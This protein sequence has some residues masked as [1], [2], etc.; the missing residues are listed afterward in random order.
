MLTTLCHRCY[1]VLVYGLGRWP[2]LLLAVPALMVLHAATAARAF[3]Q[4]SSSS[5]AD[6]EYWPEINVYE[7]INQNV[8]LMEQAS[9]GLGTDGVPVSQQVGLNLDLSVDP[10]PFR[11]Y[12]LGAPTLVED[13]SRLMTLRL[14]YRYNVSGPDI[15][16]E[17]IQNRLLAELTTRFSLWGL[18][19]S[20]RNGFDWR[21]I[22]GDYSTRYRNRLQFERPIDI[23]S[24]ELTPYVSAE[25]FYLLSSGEWNQIR[26][27]GGVQLPVVDNVTVDI[28]VGLNH[29]WQP[30]PGDIYG[31]GFKLIVA[32]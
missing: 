26:Y 18:V 32:F 24:Y 11:R 10:N 1:S 6:Y 2:A 14:G 4:S 22:S 16:P 21:W 15:T 13:R 31:M 3:A 28:Y 17:K 12:V 29:V 5:A 8:R 9:A 23:N 20:D 19:A 25:V 27:R 30:T 7:R